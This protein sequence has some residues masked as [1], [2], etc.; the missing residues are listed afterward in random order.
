[1]R[2]RLTLWP[3][4]STLHDSGTKGVSLGAAGCR[5]FLKCPMPMARLWTISREKNEMYIRRISAINMKIPFWSLSEQAEETVL[6]D[7]RATENF[8]DKDTWQKMRIGSHETVKPITI[9][10]IDG[11][12]NS[13][14]K[15]TH[16]C[17]LWIWYDGRQKLQ[18]FYIAALEKKSIILGYSFLYAFNPTINWQKGALPRDL[19]IQTL[20]YKYRYCNCDIFNL[21]KKAIEKTGRPKEGE[22]IY[23]RRSIAQD[24]AREAAKTQVQLTKQMVLEEYKRHT[25]V[26]SEK[27]SLCFPPKQKEDMAIPL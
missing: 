17:W 4:Y 9:Y 18:C 19:H 8:L 16:Y 20:W 3:L 26:F 14:G 25:K 1:M 7:S 13:Q 11:T 24:W 21:Q 12:E 2:K 27:K 23:M 10:N 22:A 6:I 15:I 5:G